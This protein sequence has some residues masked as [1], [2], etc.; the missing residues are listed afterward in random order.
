MDAHTSRLGRGNEAVVVHG[1]L[2]EGFE[3][4]HGAGSFAPSADSA[5][6]AGAAVGGVAGSAGGGGRHCGTLKVEWLLV[7]TEGVRLRAAPRIRSG[8]DLRADVL[9]FSGAVS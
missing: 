8:S 1:V 5:W 2:V 7:W 4:V 6:M 3:L 9:D